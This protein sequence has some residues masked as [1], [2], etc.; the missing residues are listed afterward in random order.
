MLIFL[1]HVLLFR[2]DIV[3]NH[4]KLTEQLAISREVGQH[5]GKDML[6]KYWKHLN[7]TELE[8]TNIRTHG[9]EKEHFYQ[10]NWLF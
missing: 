7:K 3:Q 2:N 9:K 5:E 10:R 8:N 6:K 1:Q 4:D